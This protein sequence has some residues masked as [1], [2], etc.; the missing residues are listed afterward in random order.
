MKKVV[1]SLLCLTLVVSFLLVPASSAQAVTWS[2]PVVTSLSGNTDFTFTL[3]DPF[4]L[5]FGTVKTAKGLTVPSGFVPGELQFASKAVIVKN[6]EGSKASVCYFLPTYRYGWNGGIYQWNSSAWSA[7]SST[8]TENKEGGATICST[9][10]ADG[11]YAF[12]IF[13][14]LKSVPKAPLPEC[15]DDFRA[16]VNLYY[17]DDE[18]TPDTDAYTV[19][20]IEIYQILALGSRV[21]YSIFNQNPSGSVSGALSLS[22]TVDG[23][24]DTP[25]RK[26]S[27]AFLLDDPHPPFWM[28]PPPWEWSEDNRLYVSDVSGIYSPDW[29][30]VRITTP[31]CY[32]DYSFSSEVMYGI[33]PSGPF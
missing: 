15:G 18:S 20:S 30:T 12:L 5:S 2:D 32:K 1:L 33:L 24:I 19:V 28:L 10:S 29:F 26:M 13:Y 27:F 31:T 11:T 4:S 8:L 3:T 16:M 22:G 21:S 14:S 9:I 25:G 6:L 7:L 17:L 23:I